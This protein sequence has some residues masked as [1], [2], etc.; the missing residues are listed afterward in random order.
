VAITTISFDISLLELLLPPFTGGR[1]TIATP[2]IGRDPRALARLLAA[3]EATSVQA[4]PATWQ[5][6]LADGWSGGLH[7]ILSGGD[8]LSTE[9]ARRL[10]TRGEEVWNLYGPTETTIWSMVERVSD[11]G[12]GVHLGHPLH[13]TSIYLLDDA[14]NPIPSGGRGEIWIGG[15]GVARGYLNAPE[16]T[17]AR[18]VSDPF[19]L[20]GRMYRTGDMG[21]WRRDGRL[22]YLGR[23]DLQAKV[24]GFR[25]E[26]Q[27][28][29]RA[30]VAL[31]GIRDAVVVT[32]GSP[33]NQRLVAYV[34]TDPGLA[35]LASEIRQR[36]GE[37]L[38]GYM[39]PGIVTVLESLPL[40]GSGKVDRNALPDPFLKRTDRRE[41]EPPEGDLEKLVA[42]VWR[43]L[44]GVESVS[45]GDNFFE[46]GGHS[47]QS[48]QAVAE[49]ERQTGFRIDPREFFFSTLAR[50]AGALSVTGQSSRE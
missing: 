12:E 22:E 42:E 25:I 46:L 18:F 36:L 48:I 5:M 26:L 4:T 24:Q 40:T 35:V 16:L 1:V 39:I 7:R 44:L 6:L 10:L 21:R 11:V 38:P 9:L 32:R 28:V 34:V 43:S 20:R 8:V 19:L 31:E 14:G 13:N 27:E 50:L 47:L 37:R 49:I 30:L 17:S 23:R 15:G 33:D 41:H 45:R 3:A 29:E 2:G